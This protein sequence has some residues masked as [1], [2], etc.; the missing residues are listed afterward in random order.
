MNKK[1]QTI[2]CLSDYHIGSFKNGKLIQQNYN[3]LGK[4]IKRASA[5]HIIIM[6][7]LPPMKY[8]EQLTN[9]E[10]N[11]LKKMFE[12]VYKQLRKK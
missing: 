1:I 9:K 7:D 12:K 4:K 3:I 8:S 5:E 11:Q 6:G 2:T 10:V